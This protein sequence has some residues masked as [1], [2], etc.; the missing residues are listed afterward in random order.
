[1]KTII[2]YTGLLGLAINVI[3]GFVLSDYSAFNCTL[4][5]G[6]II[7]N[8]VLMYLVS[9]LTLKDGF[10]ISLNVLFPLFFFAEFTCGLF[11]PELWKDNWF[12]ITL[13]ISILIE[14]VVL[15]ITNYI[16][17]NI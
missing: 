11:S 16:S 13:A 15:I 12:V 1:M 3:C 14:G 8:M 4:T 2:L 7:L 6:V 17:K 9:V 5:C 10:R